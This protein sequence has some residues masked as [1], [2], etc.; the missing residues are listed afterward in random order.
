MSRYPPIALRR[1]IGHLGMLDGPGYE[2]V[3]YLKLLAGLENGDRVWDL[4]CGC[5][6]LELALESARWEGS[7]IGTDIHPASIRWARRRITPRYP[8]CRFEHADI[9]NLAYHPGG[10]LTAGEWLAGFREGDFRVVAAKSFFTHLLPEETRLYLRAIS[11]RLIENGRGLLT[12]FIL[13]DRA[14]ELMA[15]GKSAFRFRAPEPDAGYAVRFLSAPSAAVAYREDFLRVV[16]AEAGLEIAGDIRRGC[17]S[18]RPD[19][20]SFQDIVV[21]SRKTSAYLPGFS[22]KADRPN[23]GR[24]GCLTSGRLPGNHPVKG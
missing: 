13:D 22:R 1:H 17:W 9:R 23:S 21:V 3:A 2:F 10:K 6:M 12:F 18:G 20:L 11:D 8:C 14:E 5:G 15:A 7:L 4:G 24:S 16:L 19:G